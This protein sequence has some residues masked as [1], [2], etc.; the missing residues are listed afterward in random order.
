MND[1]KRMMYFLLVVCISLFAITVAALVDD[2]VLVIVLITAIIAIAVWK[3]ASDET[4]RRKALKRSLHS[5]I[6]GSIALTALLLGLFLLFREVPEHPEGRYSEIYVSPT[7]LQQAAEEGDLKKISSYLLQYN[8]INQTDSAGRTAL[9]YA[10]GAE[11]V[12]AV[13]L[14]LQ[15]GA[16]PD[17][18]DGVNNVTPLHWAS[19]S[20]NVKIVEL[21]ASR[22]E[23]IDAQNKHGETAAE[24][25]MQ[26]GNT[27]IIQ[28]LINFGSNIDIV[29][30]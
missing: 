25:A 29:D 13:E 10:V 6:I 12:E 24:I 8:D 30:K 23:N 27:E 19:G 16:N 28:L 4:F 5:L 21:L 22:V 11:Q 3:G 9:H 26:T 20:G 17:I 18:Q 2:P 14:L 1:L 15:S 7:R